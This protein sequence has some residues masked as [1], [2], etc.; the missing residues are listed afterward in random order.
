MLIVTPSELLGIL[1][2]F[3]TWAQ[4]DVRWVTLLS[5]S[6]T[7]L[8][9]GTPRRSGCQSPIIPLHSRKGNAAC[10]LIIKWKFNLQKWVLWTP[11]GPIG[12]PQGHT[13]LADIHFWH[14]LW[15]S[16]DARVNPSFL[17]HAGKGICC[18][19]PVKNME[20][21]LAKIGFLDSKW[22]NLNGQGSYTPGCQLLSVS[23][24]G[25]SRSYMPVPFRSSN[26]QS[27]WSPTILSRSFW[28]KHK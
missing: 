9:R 3:Y 12:I 20:I 23:S 7:Q 28:P 15:R 26:P 11:N 27:P 8:I 24:S 13:P 21:Y 14:P 5:T 25:C 4:S 19:W 10:D 22:S 17:L 16:L 18:M 1:F 2:T 6:S